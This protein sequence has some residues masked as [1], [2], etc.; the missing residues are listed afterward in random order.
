MD[1]ALYTSFI[2]SLPVYSDKNLKKK[3]SM[4]PIT[5]N[6]YFIISPYSM[7]AKEPVTL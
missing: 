1:S 5:P 4:R 3:T 2:P 7:P 6:I